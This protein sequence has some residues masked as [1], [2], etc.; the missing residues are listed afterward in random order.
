MKTRTTPLSRLPLS[1]TL[2]LGLALA[3]VSGTPASA[4]DADA[5]ARLL[6]APRFDAAGAERLYADAVLRNDVAGLDRALDAAMADT[7]PE[8]LRLHA[9]LARAVIAWQG[10]DDT[11]AL[12]MADRAAAL[13][14]GP[15]TWLLQARLNDARGDV[16]AAR[17]GYARAFE[18]SRDPAE[19]SRI[20]LRI[21][22][23]DP[24]GAG[25][26]LAALARTD[27]AQGDRY[28]IV[29]AL[30]GNPAVALKLY[31]PTAAG[32]G[33]ID[34]LRRAQ[35]ALT[36]GDTEAARDAAW[37]AYRLAR[38]PPDRRYALALLVEGYR[39]ARNLAGALAFLEPHRASPEVEETRIDLLLELGRYDAALAE[40]T[41]ATAPETRQRLLELLDLAG[42]SA[43]GEGEYRRLI[44][45]NPSRIEGYRALAALELGRG[46]TDAATAVFAAFFA[47]NRG[48]ADLLLPAAKQM[49]AMG[50]S[51][52]A[53]ALMKDASATP[54]MAV[55]YRFF[56]VDAY[57][58]RGEDAA[59]LAELDRL[60]AQLPAA[61]PER[62]AVADAYESLGKQTA[63]LDLLRALEARLPSLDYD[64]R[65]RIATLAGENGLGEE[66]LT[67]WRRLWAEATLPARKSYLAKQIVR[68]AQ[69]IGAMDRLIGA[70]DPGTSGRRVNEDE[71]T[72]LV[73]LR[74][75]TGNRGAAIAD[76]DRYASVS[77]ATEAD[78]LRRQIGIYARLGDH[79]RV[80]TTLHRLVAV[81]P[82][83][84]DLYL[85]QLTLN[86]VRFPPDGEAEAA[87][88]ARIEALL[89]AMHKQ[90][91]AVGRAAA[92]EETRFAAAVYSSAGF[93]D[94]ARDAY[95]RAAA[96]EPT[97]MDSRAQLAD[98]L[99]R[100]GQQGRAAALLQYAADGNGAAGGFGGAID[101]LVAVLS[102]EPNGPPPPPGLAR[103]ATARLAWAERR[104]LERIVVDGEDTRLYALLADLA[105]AQ[106]DFGLQLRAY[107]N[108]MPIAGDQ[109]PAVLRMLVTLS[110]GGAASGS[111]GTG[112]A[113]GDVAAKL[114]FGRRL[115]A[116]RRDYPPDVYIDL[117]RTLLSVGDR[118]GAERAFAMMRDGAG[119]VDVDRVKGDAYADQGF[120][121]PA[122][123][124]YDRALL[125]DADDPGLVLRA[126]ILR[127]QKGDL[128]P[129]FDAYWK[130][131]AAL[132]LR[133]PLRGN[134]DEA[135]SLDA[136]QYYPTLV[137]GLMLSWPDDGDTASRVRSQFAALFDPA[138]DAAVAERADAGAADHARLALLTDL[139]RRLADRLDDRSFAE[140]ID[141]RLSPLFAR[142]DRVRRAALAF[143]NRMGWGT[144]PATDGDWIAHSLAA[145]A[146]GDDNGELAQLIA[147]ASGDPAAI[148]VQ[149]DRAMTA[150]TRNQAI[151][152]SGEARPA[153]AS[154]LYMLL[155]K[156]V[157]TLPPARFRTLILE[158][159]E[160]A[161]YRDRILLD[162]YR[163]G[164]GWYDRIERAAGRPLLTDDAL[165]G[166]LVDSGN[167]P[168]PYSRIAA[169]NRRDAS[170][171]PGGLVQR[172]TVSSKLALYERLV[173]RMRAQ[174]TETAYQEALVAQ[175]L[176][177]PLDTAQRARLET[178]LLADI[179]FDRGLKNRA[180]TFIVQK[181]LV[182]DPDPGNRAL[183]LNVARTAAAR[184]AAARHL[185]EFLQAV[186][187]SDNAAAYRAL[188]ALRAETTAQYQGID[189]AAP[190]IRDRLAAQRR[191]EI[192]AFLALDR[193]TPEQAAAFYR[194][195]LLPARSSGV[196]SERAEVPLYYR[197]L[198]MLAP[199]NPV[200]LAGLLDTMWAN[201][202]RA[203]F[204]A[205][206]ATYVAGH[207]EDRDAASV[208]QM[209]QRLI[210]Q[211][212]AAVAVAQTTGADIRNDDWLVD[213]VNRAAASRETRDE[214]D[215]RTLFG[216]LY[217][218]YARAA[219]SDPAVIEA[220][221]RRALVERQA[222][223]GSDAAPLRS[224]IDAVPRGA[225]AVRDAL[226]GRWR[227]TA[228]RQGDDSSVAASRAQL[229]RALPD[230]DA[231]SQ[232]DADLLDLLLTPT[233]TREFQQWRR[234]LDPALR[235]YQPHLDALIAAGLVKQGRASD[236][237]AEGLAALAAGTIRADA[238]DQLGVLMARTDTRLPADL[239]PALTRMLAAT[240]TL[241]T[242]ARIR[243]ANLLAGAGDTDTAARL[244]DAALLQILYPAALDAMQGIDAQAQLARI[245]A[246]LRH[247]PDAGA[248]RATHARLVERID[249]E[250][251]AQQGESRTIRLPA[252]DAAS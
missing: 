1:L 174:G 2:S 132:A 141:E 75:A 107:S 217:P 55:P 221:R 216:R 193:A 167:S 162:I 197:K 129:A 160:Q 25:D 101:A 182:L 188:K 7:R 62:I 54:G 4:Q 80:E 18:A 117:A 205:M 29:A 195:F 246:G 127:E 247:W 28:A 102:P 6:N 250:L 232:A 230:P 123:A 227:A 231:P 86:A 78:R 26:A 146:E 220:E 192:D 13:R 96:M 159:L 207:A 204:V 63:A 128:E 121:D 73:E 47:A 151:I 143:R 150:E 175:L 61:S 241:G 9:L 100:Q 27:P 84:A 59:A 52:A 8:P 134:G 149:L 87:Q 202:D 173:A 218:D 226:R 105:Q 200:Y 186:F 106:A 153:M 194:D 77:G 12:A 11:G 32:G 99:R 30:V 177:A 79:A 120:V 236:R 228:S 49:I 219:A 140:W 67:R 237:I 242:D 89:A 108:A 245:V 112:P 234:A 161:P 45:A 206:L 180:T 39:N 66:A 116:L 137:E 119:L 36:T 104:I 176:A 131:I 109:R 168:V 41:G 152:A 233:L 252:M 196:A 64:Q 16:A 214:V 91:G 94:R 81:D 170:A 251:G 225:T 95:R 110:S 156:A 223:A 142:D 208:L 37:T 190:I 48:R 88:L 23:L 3:A 133:Q 97:D 148:R 163:S 76:V 229:L 179:G 31:S 57:R 240:P 187:A 238:L 184:Y 122:L 19:R 135:A 164:G 157:D 51:D 72:L 22:L 154:P 199:D 136:R 171:S 185:P 56:L 85:R 113:L 212:G 115:L 118:P 82:K 17:A 244:L 139:G 43:E 138:V 35:W 10:G 46:R 126:A 155:L 191:A 144:A 69:R 209:A 83:N 166:L 147:L 211:D 14:P 42:R 189:Y 130:A 235:A 213:L 183:L 71:L 68:T 70:L 165:I 249:R 172:F 65:V 243:Y 38:T 222:P 92:I 215:F 158:P 90:S 15:E 58:Q 53:L 181:L 224:V 98:L 33:G 169:A 60:S 50:L 124:S 210:G 103:L 198:A 203:G 145:Q 21:A 24:A 20:G 74:I 40:V 239:R 248:A 44:A 201:A 5:V 178:A 114:S 111:G 34:A 93:A 125:R